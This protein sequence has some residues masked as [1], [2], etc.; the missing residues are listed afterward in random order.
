MELRILGSLEVRENGVPLDAGGPKPRSLLAVLAVHAGETVPADR[1]VDDLWGER[2]PRSASHLLH[3]YVSNLRKL[4]GSRLVTRAPGYVLELGSEELDARRFERLLADGRRALAAGDPET[5]A[6]ALQAGLALWRGPALADFVFEPFAQSEISRL[7]EL[8][9][10]AGVEWCAAQLEL[11]RHA[12]VVADL[13][14]MVAANPLRERPRAQLMLALYRSGR[15]ADALEEYANA[16]RTLVD[17]LG[18]EPGTAL[19]RLQQAVLQQDPDL[20]LEPVPAPPVRRLVAVLVADVGG[21]RATGLDPEAQRSA[22]VGAQDELAALL[23]SYGATVY[24]PVGDAVVGAFG[25]DGVR[26]DDT[27]RAVRAAAEAV[28]C[29]S[30]RVA[31]E[32]GEVV[33]D[34]T[35]ITGDAASVAAELARGARPGE[36]HLGETAYALVRHAVLAE[37]GLRLIDVMPQ[38]PAL[39]RRLDAELVGRRPELDAL[40]EALARAVAGTRAEVVTVVGEPGVGKSRLAEE[41]VASLGS[42]IAT[43]VGHCGLD[44]GSLSGPLREVLEQIAAGRGAEYLA[45]LVRPTDAEG[46]LAATLAAVLDVSDSTV[47]HE[48]VV[49]A[50]RRLLEARAS[51]RPLLLV[52]EDVHLARRSLLDFVLHLAEFARAPMLVVC[53]ARPELLEAREDWAGSR[54]NASVLDLDPLSA[55]ESETL[56][57]TLLDAGELPDKVRAEIV[58]AAGGNPLFLEQ[59]LAMLAEAEHSL[60]RVTLP[61]TIRALLAARVDR[62]GPAE[63]SVAERAAVIGHRFSVAAVAALVTEDAQPSVSRHLRALVRKGYLREAGDGRGFSFRHALIADAVYCALAK[64]QRALLHERVGVWLEEEAG[65][66]EDVVGSHFERAFRYLEEL[67]AVDWHARRLAAQGAAR[68]GVAGRRAIAHDDLPAAADLLSRAAALAQDD[69]SGRLQ[70]LPDLVFA[71][72]ETAAAAQAAEL[73]EEAVER[74][75]E[76]GDSALEARAR[77]EHAHARLMSERGGAVDA[78][79]DEGRRALALFE[80]AGDDEG[81]ARAL[82]LIAV[83][84]RFRGEQAARREVLERALRH[85]TRGGSL[86]LE[87]RIRDSLGGVFNYGTSA[88]EEVLAYGESSLAWARVHGDRLQVADA[89]AHGVGRPSAMLGQFEVARRVVAEARSIVEDLGLVTYIAGVASAAGYIEMLAGDPEAAERELR[90]AYELVHRTGVHGSYFGMG[91]REELAQALYALGRDEEA[92]RLSEETERLAAL[93]DVQAQV[94]WRS[95]RAKTFARAGRTEEAEP[96]AREAVTLAEATELMLVRAGALADLGDVLALAGRGAD[97]AVQLE[98]AADVYARKGDRVSAARLR[99]RAADMVP[100]ADLEATRRSSVA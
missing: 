40:T 56:V 24:R 67:R 97:A 11:G 48:E 99:S 74:A 5:A 57:D 90:A 98:L 100:R 76:R 69:D 95:V 41:L 28:R 88:V 68:L 52:L 19:R 37:D 22:V 7:E 50:C 78:A 82:Y 33:V 72:R 92:A 25:I 38:A 58:A 81:M 39:E 18:I 8:R 96:L 62:L 12:E 54:D 71:L 75:R 83:G 93:D 60:D 10:F 26:E 79:F 66:P 46:R 4:V 1:L 29:V 34:G 53:L 6:G 63:R 86:R 43:V 85:A 45:R 20:E 30:A 36:V 61:P 13:Q 73:A 84:H 32:T 9:L 2:P 91:V 65:E 87:S 44:D 31:V 51:Q 17:E 23:R 70:L 80:D 15:H 77:I 16:R 59:L 89:L 35:T 21:S 14:A 42:K 55:A 49:W 47:A 27:L 3:V 94:L 64:R